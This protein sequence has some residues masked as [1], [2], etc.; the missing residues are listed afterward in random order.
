[1]ATKGAGNRSRG[2]EERGIG[3]N[4]EKQNQSKIVIYFGM[5]QKNDRWFEMNKKQLNAEDCD[6]NK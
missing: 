2:I 6:K 1:L 3:L 5:M 4:Y